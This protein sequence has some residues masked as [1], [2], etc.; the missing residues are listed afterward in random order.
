MELKRADDFDPELLILFDAYVHGDID[1]RGFIDRAAKFAVGG[2]TAAM[3]LDAL[4]PRFAEAQQVPKD[5]ARLKAE[6]VE[7]PSPA[8]SG[9][10]RG[11]LVR[12]AKASG[13]LP[14]VL[15]IHENRGLNPHIEPAAL[16]TDPPSPPRYHVNQARGRPAGHAPP[17]PRG[18][19]MP[20]KHVVG[21][22][23][24]ALAHIGEG[25]TIP[26]MGMLGD[27]FPDAQFV[28]TGVIGPDGNAHGPNEYLHVPDHGAADSGRG[29]AGARP[30]RPGAPS[31]SRRFGDVAVCREPDAV[32]IRGIV[33]AASLLTLSLSGCDDG[34]TRNGR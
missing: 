34:S 32:P 16:V 2:V 7:Y 6:H 24:C 31:L 13:K 28:V 26:F 22:V 1:R 19:S 5:D 20:S 9:K 17:S 4:N 3:L 21:D 10:M 15:V 18:S 23:R 27:Q 29:G 14:A 8:G 11:Y 33:A 30:H 25:G 12:P